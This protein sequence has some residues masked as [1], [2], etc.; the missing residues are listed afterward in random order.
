MRNLVDHFG[1]VNNTDLASGHDKV[2]SVDH[3]MDGIII[4]R[5]STLSA[6]ESG[7]EILSSKV[8]DE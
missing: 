8:A 6:G 1:T 4:D 5:A 7:R 3:R 2:T